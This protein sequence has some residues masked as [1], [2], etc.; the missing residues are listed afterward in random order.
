MV[1]CFVYLCY[2]FIHE[3]D[4]SLARYF[5]GLGD[6]HHA[7][8]ARACALF[9]F[10]QAHFNVFLHRH[11]VITAFLAQIAVITQPLEEAVLSDGATALLLIV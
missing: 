6:V 11:V 7:V 8:I 5:R 4:L 3:I 10:K 9:D 2:E 1:V